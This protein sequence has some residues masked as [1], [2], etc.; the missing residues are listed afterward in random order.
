MLRTEYCPFAFASDL[1]RDNLMRRLAGK[2]SQMTGRWHF[3]KTFPHLGRGSSHQDKTILDIELWSPWRWNEDV[4]TDQELRD[5]VAGIDNVGFVVPGYRWKR[6]HFAHP[7]AYKHAV[8]LPSRF[9]RGMFKTIISDNTSERQ[10]WVMPDLT[11]EG[12]DIMNDLGLDDFK[13]GSDWVET[14][15]RNASKTWV[16]RHFALFRDFDQYALAKLRF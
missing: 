10:D 1:E 2:I 12:Q 3:A 14:P 13:L 6:P 8:M 16:S 7:A 11:E 5:A 9:C 15:R 4:L